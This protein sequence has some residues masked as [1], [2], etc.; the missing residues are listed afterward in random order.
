MLLFS[1]KWQYKYL[2]GSNLM[3][4]LILCVVDHKTVVFIRDLSSPDAFF[5][6]ERKCFLYF[7]RSSETAK[8]H[9][10]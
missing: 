3:N 10:G 9:R 2:R 7:G 8:A 6:V 1:W 4:A 5:K